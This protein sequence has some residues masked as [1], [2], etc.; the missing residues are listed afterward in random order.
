VATH[1]VDD[2]DAGQQFGDESRWNHRQE[3]SEAT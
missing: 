3:S 2:V 1:D